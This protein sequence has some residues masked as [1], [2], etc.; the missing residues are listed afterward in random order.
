MLVA[1]G[2]TEGSGNS[3]RFRKPRD[4]GHG[5]AAHIF[6]FDSRPITASRFSPPRRKSS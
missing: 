2:G 4:L 1:R 3:P 5:N 6:V